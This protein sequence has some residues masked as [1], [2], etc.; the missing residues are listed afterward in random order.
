MRWPT[1]RC[2]SQQLRRPRGL[3][4]A[5]VCVSRYLAPGLRAYGF[6]HYRGA[7]F[8]IADELI[9]RSA[10]EVS[11]ANR[12]CPLCHRCDPSHSDR[13]AYIESLRRMVCSGEFMPVNAPWF[14]RYLPA[15]SALQD[16]VAAIVTPKGRGRPTLCF[17]AHEMS[18]NRLGQ[19]SVAAMR[20]LPRPVN[21]SPATA[22]N[23]PT[24]FDLHP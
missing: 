2:S 19:K 13:R 1:E 10:A 5:E 16:Q 4:S 15:P 14:S 3:S 9:H 22:A 23:V 21:E 11:E 12:P 8:A 20:R 6:R 18:R 24:V 17:H 7:L